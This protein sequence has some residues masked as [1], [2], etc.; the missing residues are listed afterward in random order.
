MPRC[1][2]LQSIPFVRVA[3]IL[4]YRYPRTSIYIHIQAHL[5]HTTH[6]VVQI[7]EEYFIECWTG[8][9]RQDAAHSIRL[10]A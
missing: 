4:Y 10:S 7:G 8:M 9:I 1:A 6:L 3:I 5:S 2:A